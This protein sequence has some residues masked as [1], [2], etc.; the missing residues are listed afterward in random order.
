MMDNHIFP[1]TMTSLGET[2]KLEKIMGGEDINNRL[3]TLGLTPGTELC[4]VQDAGGPLLIS[5]R[6]SRIALGRGMAH[7]IMVSQTII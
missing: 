5:V 6:D 4:L 1:L 7:K 2:V 3:A